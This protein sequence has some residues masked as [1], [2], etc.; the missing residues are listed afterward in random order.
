M[1]EAVHGGR[2]RNAMRRAD[3]TNRNW[4]GDYPAAD[5]HQVL[6]SLTIPGGTRDLDKSAALRRGF[7]MAFARRHEGS[8]EFS[9]LAQQ[10]IVGKRGGA[11][12]LRQKYA[13]TESRTVSKQR[14]KPVLQRCRIG[15]IAG[16]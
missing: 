6:K 11:M 4:I 2:E 10:P 1:K 7:Q 15:D 13:V 9:D 8:S 12:R 14:G 3:D 16:F 5:I